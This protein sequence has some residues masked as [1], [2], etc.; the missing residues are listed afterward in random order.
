MNKKVA[1][2][3]NKLSI[4]RTPARVAVLEV[5]HKSSAPLDVDTVFEQLQKNGIDVDKVTVYRTL[6]TLTDFNILRKVEFQEGKFRYELASL[7]HHHH[8]ICTNCGRVEDIR[9]CGMEEVENKLQKRTAFIIKQ[10][11]AEFFG[12][13]AKCQ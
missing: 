9:E 8:L 7:P 11:N 4:K 12:L 3:M 10:H 2:V 5:F 13:C 6:N 1:A